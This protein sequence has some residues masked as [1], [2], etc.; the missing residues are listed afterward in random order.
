MTK[1][2]GKR[3]QSR[4][5][6][7]ALLGA[8]VLIGGTGLGARA[9]DDE[10]EAA[11]AKFLHSVMQALGL[12]RAGDTGIQY[13]ERSPLVLPSGSQLPPPEK[14]KPA[15]K[16]PDW[17][18]DPDVKRAKAMKE[19]ARKERRLNPE[20]VG[21]LLPSQYN[22]PAGAAPRSR[23]DG[24]PGGS[25]EE[26]SRPMSPYELGSKNPISSIWASKE[27][28]ATFTGEPP[29]GS[30]TEPPA[31]YRTPSPSQPY[32]IG[33]QKWVPET[34]DRNVPIR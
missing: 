27:E 2:S 8:L 25:V 5:V 13:R 18:D 28:Y 19:A 7:A 26:S 23:P 12:R 17:P 10:D 29:R 24:K 4:V 3:R 33:E 30:L 15:A 6:L 34:T 21:P 20:E 11:D 31:G 14:N 1:F 22:L 16:A 9:E 32:G